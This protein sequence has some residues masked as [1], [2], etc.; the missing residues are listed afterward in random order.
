MNLVYTLTSYPP[1][2]GGAQLLQHQLA[3]RLAGRHSIR[4][5]SHWDSDRSDWLLG[6]TLR[7]PS[8]TREYRVDGIPIRRLGLSRREKLALL[9]S[10]GLYYAF[11][12]A[13]LG[14]ITSSI[15]RGL[16][17]SLVDADLIHNVRIGR[18]GISL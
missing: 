14:P 17:P 8:T 1:A 18:E 6:T 15:E 4:V 16:A 2:I 7:A 9:P 10:V 3:R 13:A 5:V 11:M 12:G